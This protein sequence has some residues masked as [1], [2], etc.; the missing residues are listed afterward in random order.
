MSYSMIEIR[1]DKKYYVPVINGEKQFHLT[2]KNEHSAQFN[3]VN[4]EGIGWDKLE[5]QGWTIVEF[6]GSEYE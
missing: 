2:S 4:S 5:K 1:L 6:W 3:A